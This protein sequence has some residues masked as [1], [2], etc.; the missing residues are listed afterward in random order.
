MS[1]ELKILD[2]SLSMVSEMSQPSLSNGD[3]VFGSNN[4]E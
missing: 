3:V 2:K 4:F 1:K